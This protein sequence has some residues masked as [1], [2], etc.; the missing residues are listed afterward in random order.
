M[1]TNWAESSIKPSSITAV[2]FGDTRW[3]DLL[4]RNLND[5]GFVAVYSIIRA[6][7]RFG[8]IGFDK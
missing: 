7:P 8:K 5:L 2:P 1:M 6:F 4:N 3:S